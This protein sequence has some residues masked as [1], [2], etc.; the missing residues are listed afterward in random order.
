M[1][2]HLF[3]LIIKPGIWLND[4]L[5]PL[6][7]SFFL[8]KSI[9][10][11]HHYYYQRPLPHFSTHFTISVTIFTEFL[12]ATEIQNGIYLYYAFIPGQRCCLSGRYR[13]CM[14]LVAFGCAEK[15]WEEIKNLHNFLTAE[16]DRQMEWMLVSGWL[17]ACLSVPPRHSYEIYIKRGRTHPPAVAAV[18]PWCWRSSAAE[19]LRQ[20]VSGF[21]CFRSRFRL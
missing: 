1:F 16:W 21:M 9:Y 18:E 7:S 4:F 2:L 15:E 11:Q 20:T 8:G 10:F 12:V 13:V 14:F 6:G 5:A 3:S 17:A 19:L